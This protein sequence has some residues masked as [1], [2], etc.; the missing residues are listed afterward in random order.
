ML[1]KTQRKD[2]IEAINKI[3]IEWIFLKIFCTVVVVVRVILA[4]LAVALSL[5]CGCL[6]P[7]LTV[8]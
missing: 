6:V 1:C 2:V 3:G 4:I 5:P 7:G 8:I